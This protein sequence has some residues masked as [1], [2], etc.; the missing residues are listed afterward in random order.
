MTGIYKATEILVCK[1]MLCFM[2]TSLKF[3]V[4]ISPEASINFNTVLWGKNGM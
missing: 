4:S 1:W 3:G 2:I